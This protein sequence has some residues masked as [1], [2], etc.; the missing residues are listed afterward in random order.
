[1]DPNKVSI[2]DAWRQP[3]SKEFESDYFDQI[4]DAVKEAVIQGKVIYPAG[5]LIFHAYDMV[6]PDHVKVVI[7]G[8]D[9]YHNPGEA[10]G[11]CFSVPDGV[12]IPPSLKNIYKELAS[13]TGTPVPDHGN[14]TAW[15]SQGV[16][17]LNAILTV[18]KNKP[19]SHSRIGW[20]QF[21]D[22]TIKYLSDQY[23]HIVFML[24]GNFARS[25]RDLVDASR[26]LL[27]EAAHPSPLARNA[28]QGCRH[29]SAANEYLIRHGRGAIDWTL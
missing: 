2:S 13:D 26:H 16:F 6:A 27:L 17:L 15:A 23:D 11:L 14:L 1:M 10:M 18:E 29:F 7:L 28:F 24:W 25:K 22:A 5:K 12:A 19:G 21:T 8:Q 3:L 9:P 20:Q 4:S